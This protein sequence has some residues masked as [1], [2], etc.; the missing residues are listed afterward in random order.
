MASLEETFGP[1]VYSY[2]RAQALVDGFLVDVT[3]TSEVKECGFKHPV[4]LSRALWN[5]V[6]PNEE[7]KGWGQSVA[8]RLW[9]VCCLARTYWKARGGT[10][11]TYQCKFFVKRPGVRQAVY[12]IVLDCGPG[13]GGEPVITIMFPE[14]R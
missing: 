13:D 1:V 5:L 10:S 8:G 9:D 7:E 11:V 14:D 4:A 3:D 6:E 12:T 2:T